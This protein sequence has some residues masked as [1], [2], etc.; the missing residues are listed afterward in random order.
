MSTPRTADRTV[1]ARSKLGTVSLLHFSL[2]AATPLTVIAAGVGVMLALAGQTGIALGYIVIAVCLTLFSVGYTSLARHIHNGAFYALIARGL[3]RTPVIVWV[4][5][6]SCCALQI[7]LFGLLGLTAADVFTHIGLELPWWVFALAAWLLI[8][9]LGSRAVGVDMK[10]FTGLGIVIL[11]LVMSLSV[12]GITWLT[13]PR[14]LSQPESVETLGLTIQYDLH[15][16]SPEL[17]VGALLMAAMAGA[18]I[19]VYEGRVA[20][21]ARRTPPWSTELPLSPR[22]IMADTRGRF[23]GEVTVTVLIPA[24]NEEER[25]PATLASL[26]RQTVAPD[27]IVVVADNCTDATP[28]I[29]RSADV[30]VFFSVDN[31]EKKAGALNQALASMLPT[32]GPNDL[33]MVMDADTYFASDKFIETAVRCMTD[34]R[35]MMAVGGLFLGE[36]GHGLLGQFQRNEYTRY[37]REIRRRR[38]RVFV[39][40]GTASV[41][42]PAALRTV[43]ESRGT[44]LPGVHG[45]VYDTIALTEDNELTLAIKT[46]GGLM[47]S[48]HECTVITELMPTWRQLW[49]QRLRWQRGALENLSAYGVTPT[50]T[51]YWAQQ[52]AIGYS[53]VALASYFALMGITVMAIDSWV[54]FPFWGCLSM[55]FAIERIV[56]AWRGGRRARLLAATVIPELVY[57]LYIGV[58]FLK[59]VGDMVFGRSASW[60]HDRAAKVVHRE[61]VAA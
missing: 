26:A 55:V 35:A 6:T 19:A 30:D 57:D 10:R 34:D 20:T 43:A 49:R 39:L 61:E 36:Q 41:F 52:I 38:G 17:V 46:L 4:A 21:A 7:S 31:R 12:L 13:V 58:V 24:H 42:R 22:R 44:L 5:V 37:T 40:S 18:G 54:W 53:A 56:T 15:G 48:P 50:T 32:L 29:A 60:G 27:R 2:A 45:D 16:P 33:V 51:R 11:A 3:V 14:R 8:G 59:G 9:L 23:D 25:L 47:I 1:L 28:D